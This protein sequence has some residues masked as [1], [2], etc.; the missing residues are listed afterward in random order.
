MGMPVEVNMYPQWGALTPQAGRST[1]PT[2]LRE[3]HALG[4]L[5]AQRYGRAAAAVLGPRG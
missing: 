4:F 3:P 1:R 2:L 5:S